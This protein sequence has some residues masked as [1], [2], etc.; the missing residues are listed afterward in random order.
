MS[1]SMIAKRAGTAGSTDHHH[2]AL[3]NLIIDLDNLDATLRMFKPDIDLEV[4]RPKP[5]PPT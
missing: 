2:L 1:S 5:L 3:R 4:I